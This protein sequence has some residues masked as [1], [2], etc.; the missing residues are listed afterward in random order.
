[1]RNE[2]HITF[3]FYILVICIENCIVLCS[4]HWNRGLKQRKTSLL[5][6]NIFSLAASVS[7]GRYGISRWPVK[8]WLG[9]CLQWLDWP[10]ES[11]WVP[12][13]FSLVYSVSA[14]YINIAELPFLSSNNTHWSLCTPF[15]QPPTCIKF[16][17]AASS[18]IVMPMKKKRYF[19]IGLIEYKHYPRKHSMISTMWWRCSRQQE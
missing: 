4:C 6:E 17:K 8:W 13:S 10:G 12:S 19:F 1:M 15:I 7:F 9:Q 2:L 11:F 3:R 5:M 18:Q 16:L 14:D